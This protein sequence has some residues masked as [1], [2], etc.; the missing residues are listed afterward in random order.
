MKVNTP[1]PSPSP[2]SIITTLKSEYQPRVIKTIE[3]TDEE[4]L[5]TVDTAA[6]QRNQRILNKVEVSDSEETADGDMR[7][8]RR[9]RRQAKDK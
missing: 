6:V 1:L 2:Q 7:V 4:S 3:V 9:N 8:K 5:A